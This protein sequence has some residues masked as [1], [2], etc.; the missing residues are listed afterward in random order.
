MPLFLRTSVEENPKNRQNPY[1]SPRSPFI[2]TSHIIYRNR[3]V[4]G[5]AKCGLFLSILVLLLRWLIVDQRTVVCL[6]CEKGVQA[7]DHEPL[8]R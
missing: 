5:S 6:H 4:W 2:D 7:Q 3:I 8:E 1:V